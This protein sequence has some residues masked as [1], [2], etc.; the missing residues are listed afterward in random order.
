M[1]ISMPNPL[2][3]VPP[4]NST[5]SWRNSIAFGKSTS[6][7]IYPQQRTHKKG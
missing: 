7:R 2:V 5:I 1:Q 4:F 6:Q 3:K